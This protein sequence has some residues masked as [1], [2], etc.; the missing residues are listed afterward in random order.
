MCGL[1]INSPDI[2]LMAGLRMEH[3]SLRYTGRNYDDETGKT[4]KTGRMTNSYV[5]FLP[6]ILVKWDVNDDFKIRGSY[7]QTLSRQIFS[8]GS[9]CEYQPW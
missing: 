7:T 5:N 1:I 2:N 6:S 8:F 3:T 9:Q 4:T